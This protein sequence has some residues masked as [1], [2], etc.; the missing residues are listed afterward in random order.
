VKGYVD[1]GE[2]LYTPSVC[3]AEIKTRYLRDRRDP[4]DSLSFVIE[5][6]FI[7]PLTQEIA[8]L[9]ADVKQRYGLHTVDALVYATGES[10]NL[11]VVTGDLHFKSLPNVEMI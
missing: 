5:R 7:L 6:S 11:A 3:L 2:S 10:R 9:A 4:T 8:L 1:G